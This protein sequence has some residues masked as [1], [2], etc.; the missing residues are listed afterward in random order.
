MFHKL[1][2]FILRAHQRKEPIKEEIFEKEGAF[3]K[4]E[5]KAESVELQ[6]RSRRASQVSSLPAK[7]IGNI[8]RLD[9]P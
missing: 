5:R 6:S 9:A 7:R 3:K 4:N 1:T 2:G 8:T